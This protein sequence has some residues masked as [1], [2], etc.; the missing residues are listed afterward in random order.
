MKPKVYLLVILVFF[1]LGLVFKFFLVNSPYL[2]PYHLSHISLAKTTIEQAY[3]AFFPYE[4]DSSL[5]EYQ[6]NLV[7]DRIGTTIELSFLK[8][9][10]G[11]DYN[12][13]I[14]FPIG[15]LI[16]LV[17]GLY[18]IESVTSKMPLIF[19]FLSFL[20]LEP[21]LS[22][23]TYSTNTH[24]WAFSLFFILLGY[25]FRLSKKDEITLK[26]ILITL[27]L[28]ILV[29]LFYYTAGFVAFFTGILFFSF[30]FFSKRTNFKERIVITAINYCLIGLYI[31]LD[32]LVRNKVLN[33]FFYFGSTTQEIIIKIYLYL[34]NFWVSE[35]EGLYFFQGYYNAFSGIVSLIIYIILLVIVFL[36][37]HHMFKSKT[38]TLTDLLLFSLFVASI[39]Q[40]VIYFYF[41]Q[42]VFYF[43]LI[44][45]ILTLIYFIN[46]FKMEFVIDLFILI[47]LFLIILKFL[48][49]PINTISLSN[50]HEQYDSGAMWL[51]SKVNNQTIIGDIFFIEKAN[52]LNDNNQYYGYFFI[53][54][55]YNN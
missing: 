51:S 36:F 18:L 22:A 32:P 52:L 37:I 5:L 25:L 42:M 34:I 31:L 54:P 11:L 55:S 44:S 20:I 53:S 39:I 23:Q 29:D 48:L 16:F 27:F 50:Y 24:M 6:I 28:I 49:S 3:I 33:Q 26:E 35:Q 47:F 10:I 19:L 17:S 8:I 43:F 1:L 15:I 41:N 12:L 4:N 38:K 9:L 14:Y 7:S 21:T 2:D 40:F 13:L 46:S 30:Y 45:S